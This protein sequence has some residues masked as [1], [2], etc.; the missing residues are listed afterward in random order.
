MARKPWFSSTLNQ[1]GQANAKQKGPGQRK[2]NAAEQAGVESSPAYR[3]GQQHFDEFSRIV[4]IERAERH[5]HE[6]Q[7]QQY[8]VEQR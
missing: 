8:D 3:L 2:Y 5:T 1:Q 7:E 4:Y 6:R